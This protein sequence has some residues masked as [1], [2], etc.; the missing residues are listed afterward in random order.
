MKSFLKSTLAAACGVLLVFVVVIMFFGAIFGAIAAAGEST[1]TIPS[2]G[3]LKID[4]SAINITEQQ[5]ESDPMEMLAGGTTTETIGLWNAINA[6]NT[7]ASDPA[8]KYIY[9]LTDGS[10]ASST[11]LEELRASLS[12]FKSSGKPIIAYTE[13]PSTGS[14]YLASVADKIY[15]TSY[16]GASAMVTGVSSQMIFLGDLFKRLGINMQLVRYGKY[17]SAGEMYTR[18][19]SSAENREQYQRL[20]DSMWESMSGE[21]AESRGMSVETL[22]KYIN[23]I[24]LNLPEDFLRCGMVDS[25]YTRE[26]LQNQLAVLAVKED[27][28]DV[29]MIPF[30]DYAAAKAPASK[31]SKSIAI[32][33]ADGEIIDGSDTKQI[34]GDRFAKLIE[35]A[36][37]DSTVKAVVLRVNSPGGSVLA[38][39]KI[40][41]EL[42]LLGEVKPIVASYGSYAA[43]GG[44]WISNNCD[45]IFT[46]KTTL[47][48][49][50]GVFGLIPDVSGTLK[51]IAHVNIESVNSHKHSDMLNGMRPFDDAEHNYMYRSIDNIYKL[52]LATVSEGRGISE[53]E[54]DAVGQGRVWT[55]SDALGIDLVDEIGTLEDALHY[56][57]SIAGD[58]D[59]NNWD[60]TSYPKPQTSLEAIMSLLGQSTEEEVS[61]VKAFKE[62]SEPTVVARIDRNIEIKL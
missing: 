39:E 45:K 13:S 35:K 23:N 40:K 24:E 50:I 34:A 1:P 5:Q 56:T 7:A 27:Y 57:A 43:S 30:A 2:E 46:N 58:P 48:G 10:V 17:K 47:T 32:I 6:I 53:A 3:V 22:D 28:K 20:V 15:M 38:S 11:T 51:N 62:I 42:D 12:K 33:Y 16:Q 54:V 19:S 21:I 52:F 8:V 26:Q 49:S 31:A 18:S 25:L 4:M 59:L 37:R 41:H 29:K 44:Y 60:I 55:G 36:R 61:I 9:L 14:Y